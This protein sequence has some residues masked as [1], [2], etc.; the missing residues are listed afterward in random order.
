MK[1]VVT[2]PILTSLK[3]IRL[4]WKKPVAL[5]SGAMPKSRVNDIIVHFQEGEDDRKSSWTDEIPQVIVGNFAL[6]KEGHNL[7]AAQHVVLFDTQW[8]VTDEVQGI[9]RVSRVGQKKVTQTIKLVNKSSKI[10]IAIHDRQGARMAL[11]KIV[12]AP[13]DNSNVEDRG[14][15]EEEGL[16]NDDLI[17]SGSDVEH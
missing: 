2:K 16:D 15:G 5:I 13:I 9:K 8:M 10:E 12:Q 6:L 3:A 14:K 4:L 7:T 11:Y 17:D 1:T